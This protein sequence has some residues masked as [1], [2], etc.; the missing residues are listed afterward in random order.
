MVRA[1]VASIIA[2][3]IVSALIY[4]NQAAGFVPSFDFIAEIGAFNARLGFPPTEDASWVTHAVVGVVLFG[5]LFLFVQP[6]L[7]GSAAGEGIW[8]AIVT[9]LLCMTVMMPL[10][11]NE[12]FATN[13]NVLFI[14][15]V[16]GLN[17]VY[18]LTLSVVFDALTPRD[19]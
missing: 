19:D 3:A 15:G 1:F 17:L 12:M 11:G 2:T 6:I 10:A 16:A 18:G 7:P 13:L 9:F 8:F 5:L 4:A 14:A